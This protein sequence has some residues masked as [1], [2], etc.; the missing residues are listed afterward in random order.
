M[1]FSPLSPSIIQLTKA[2][3]TRQVSLSHL[4]PDCYYADQGYT[5]TAIRTDTNVAS[6][7]LCHVACQLEASC[8]NWMW[9]SKSHPTDA[10]HEK[11][12]LYSAVTATPANAGAV[13]GLKTCP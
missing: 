3:L 6:T 5:G 13:R 2:R 10:D 9:I 7:A 4:L 12:T 8:T 1:A 11:C